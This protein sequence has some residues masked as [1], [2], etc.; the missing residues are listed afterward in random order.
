MSKKRKEEK[1]YEEFIKKEKPENTEKAIGV[2]GRKWEKYCNERNLKLTEE[3]HQ[4][5]ICQ[6]LIQLKLSPEE[7]YSGKTFKTYS[8]NLMVYLKEKVDLGFQISPKAE[9][10][11]HNTVENR[12]KMILE[13]P[14]KRVES[15][16]PLSVDEQKLLVNKLSID[17]PKH[18]TVLVLFSLG[19]HLCLRSEELTMIRLEQLKFCDDNGM[20][21]I[22]YSQG[23]SKN[24]HVI[25]GNPNWKPKTAKLFQNSED[26]KDPYQLILRYYNFRIKVPYNEDSRFFRAIKHRNFKKMPIHKGAIH[27]KTLGDYVKDCAKFVGIT[28]NVTL[29]SFR[30]S[31]CSQMHRAGVSTTAIKKTKSFHRSDKGLDPYL[32]MSLSQEKEIDSTLHLNPIKQSTNFNFNSDNISS[33]L[34]NSSN[35]ENPKP[36]FLL[37]NNQN[38]IINFHY[39]SPKQEYSLEKQ[40]TLMNHLKDQNEKETNNN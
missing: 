26:P 38:C 35:Q 14:S 20:K 16:I 33:L 32:H 34:S 15:T 28:H 2:I 8:S 36:I 24:N 30:A 31:S 22:V 3:N 39:N 27:P 1:T 29:H 11:I 19:K 23:E 12:L 37:S 6:F 21:Y 9:V 10:A 5:K 18:F 13:D 17:I 40:I 25:Y 7:E 4:K